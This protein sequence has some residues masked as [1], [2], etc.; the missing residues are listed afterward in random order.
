MTHEIFFGTIYENLQ[1]L[2]S[3]PL[4]LRSLGYVSATIKEL[5]K[6]L[7]ETPD[8]IRA[9]DVM[10]DGVKKMRIFLGFANGNSKKDY[11]DVKHQLR[12]WNQLNGFAFAEEGVVDGVVI[13][14]TSLPWEADVKPIQFDL[15]SCVKGHLLYSPSVDS[16][17]FGNSM[18]IGLVNQTLKN[19]LF[20]I[21]YRER[22]ER[23]R[24]FSQMVISSGPFGFMG[25]PTLKRVAEKLGAEC[26]EVARVWLMM[27]ADGE[28]IIK[29]LSRTIDSSALRTERIYIEKGSLSWVRRVWRKMRGKSGTF[30]L[31]FE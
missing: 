14:G 17:H 7:R 26:E 6:T 15:P 4:L 25:Y 20:P 13:I 8:N 2:A 11:K 5:R 12:R 16:I 31:N 23:I 28:L 22:I 18:Q 27:E 3:E 30:R 9:Y 10:F 29:A 19:L 21:K 1:Y 24:N